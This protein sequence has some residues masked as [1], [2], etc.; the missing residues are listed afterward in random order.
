M[1]A[2]HKSSA[3]KQAV[4]DLL[5]A[6]NLQRRAGVDFPTIWHGL[7]RDHPLVRGIPV[8]VQLASESCLSIILV[9]GD[10]LVF[11]GSSFNLE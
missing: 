1:M 4:A 7:L 2:P 8:Q 5:A 11:R 10:K 6:A 9:T 3:S